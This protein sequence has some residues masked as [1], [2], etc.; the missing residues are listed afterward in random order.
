MNN[1]FREIFTW[2]SLHYQ[3]IYICIQTF[4]SLKF[5][6]VWERDFLNSRR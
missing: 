1:L 6:D 3:Y 5:N 4:V 2:K